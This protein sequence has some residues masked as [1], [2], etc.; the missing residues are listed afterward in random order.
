M[1]KLG[2]SNL[3]LY[4]NSLGNEASRQAYRKTLLEFLELHKD[5]ICED[6][7]RRMQQNPLRVLD[8][9]VPEDQE[10]YKHTKKK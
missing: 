5:K 6:C 8:C 7:Q 3:K 2:L 1:Q 10:L 9:K 4:I